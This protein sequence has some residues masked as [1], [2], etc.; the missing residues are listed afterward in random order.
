MVVKVISG[1]SP[2]RMDIFDEM[3][4]ALDS[5]DMGE[6]LFSSWFSQEGWSRIQHFTFQAI[7]DEE[8][9]RTFINNHGPGRDGRSG[10]YSNDG[11]EDWNRLFNEFYETPEGKA[12][13]FFI[14]SRPEFLST[15]S[16][17]LIQIGKQS[18]T[19]AN[20]LG[21]FIFVQL[22]P[23]QLIADQGDTK[24]STP[25]NPVRLPELF[26]D[27]SV[28][29]SD[30]PDTL[31]EVVSRLY[32]EGVNQRALYLNMRRQNSFVG[33]DDSGLPHTFDPQDNADFLSTFVVEEL[34]DTTYPGIGFLPRTL[35]GAKRGIKM[36]T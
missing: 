36:G 16:I 30:N 1:P 26:T 6:L 23:A 35:G 21:Y 7:P 31:P 25:Y 3:Y 27:Y 24:E 4:G 10:I 19:E 9:R 11:S 29:G 13:R 8:P 32:S 20:K 18:V 22:S 15:P 14:E 2:D 17:A 5:Y 28:Y 33:Q 34:K 12:V